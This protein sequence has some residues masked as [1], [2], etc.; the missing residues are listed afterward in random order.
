MPCSMNSSNQDSSV[1]TASK[2]PGSSADLFGSLRESL[3]KTMH[4]LVTYDS[5]ALESATSD[6]QN[7][8]QY[9]ASALNG[10]REGGTTPFFDEASE[11]HYTL[12]CQVAVAL[13][14]LDRSYRTLAALQFVARDELGS[15]SVAQ[16][17]MR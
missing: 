9:L 11:E 17:L 7:L 6:Q 4:A 5:S 12:A 3:E 14:S 10:R 2:A 15:Y 16:P 8:S 1:D 13:R